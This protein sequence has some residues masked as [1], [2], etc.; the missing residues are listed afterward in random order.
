MHDQVPSKVM[1]SRNMIFG[2]PVDDLD[3]WP[4]SSQD[5]DAVFRLH[6]RAVQR[7][8]ERVRRV[9]RHFSVKEGTPGQL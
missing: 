6:H 8:S 9:D 2:K 7:Q 5:D 3:R 1:Q 4:I